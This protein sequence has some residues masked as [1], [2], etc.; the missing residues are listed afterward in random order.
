[1]YPPHSDVWGGDGALERLAWAEAY[2]SYMQGH[3][4]KWYLP[5]KVDGTCNG[6]QHI[7]A[8]TRS[9]ELASSVNLLPTKTGK[10][11]DIYQECADDAMF[12][13]RT[14]SD[15][16]IDQVAKQCTYM[17]GTSSR[18]ELVTCLDGLS[19]LQ[20]G[21]GLV[22]KAVMTTPYNASDSTKRSAIVQEVYTQLRSEILAIQTG[23]LDYFAVLT[24]VLGISVAK[25]TKA[26][27]KSYLRTVS[28]LDKL[29]L[30]VDD[31]LY[32]TPLGMA[33]YPSR[34]EISTQKQYKHWG[35]KGRAIVSVYQKTT[36]NEIDSA[37]V[38]T[39]T[40][41]NV[42]HSYDSCHMI[43]TNMAV[44]EERPGAFLYDVHDEY[45]CLPSAVD[46][47]QSTLRREFIK[48]HTEHPLD[49]VLLDQVDAEDYTIGSLA[50]DQLDSINQSEF[51]FN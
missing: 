45:G 2:Y 19:S 29:P 42:I 22:K 18:G 26:A 9:R 21:R 11:A 37:K 1:M 24:A 6:I 30:S 49:K 47:L 50:L 20:L 23:R 34:V 4:D 14:L 38:R 10:P 36:L 32:I 16:F 33:V 8:I 28:Q 39:A 40:P 43:N 7:A 5:V 15:K 25:I 27:S 41:P 35:V 48:L 3:T 13:L 46:L 12:N 44:W 51:F 31:P 17:M